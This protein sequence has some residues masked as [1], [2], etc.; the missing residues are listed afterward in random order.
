L[1]LKWTVLIPKTNMLRLTLLASVLYG[2]ANASAV[3]GEDPNL[4]EVSTKKT[5]GGLTDMTQGMP[6]SLGGAFGCTVGGK[7]GIPDDDAGAGRRVRMAFRTGT[8]EAGGCTGCRHASTLTDGLKGFEKGSLG[9][10]LGGM[11]SNY[12]ATNGVLSLWKRGGYAAS[13][14]GS[15]ATISGPGT[16]YI[17]HL[18]LNARVYHVMV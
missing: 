3:A 5:G 8:S 7:Y 16:L 13:D 15:K 4:H 6:K 9:A 1:I 18:D 17:T 12:N 2:G 10:S 11:S 14:N